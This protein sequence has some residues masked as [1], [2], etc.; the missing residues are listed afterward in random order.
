M[1]CAA[2]N[3]GIYR[4]MPN[5][6]RSASMSCRPSDLDGPVIKEGTV[7]RTA[8]LGRI[9]SSNMRGPDKNMIEICTYAA[10]PA[11]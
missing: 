6:A 10:A 2:T 5:H 3:A 1:R 9:L 11:Q 7:S 8:E 4:S